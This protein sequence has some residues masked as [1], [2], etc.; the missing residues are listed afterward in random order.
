MEDK[1]IGLAEIIRQEQN[2]PSVAGF[3]A[4]YASTNGV[5]AG[6]IGSGSGPDSGL[7]G[8]PV[9]PDANA[10]YQLRELQRRMVEFVKKRFFLLEKAIHTEEYL[11]ENSVSLCQSPYLIKELIIDG[12]LCLLI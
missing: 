9:T 4:A 3:A 10:L 8:N 7:N 12:F 5:P 2:L 11:K 1:E 6:G